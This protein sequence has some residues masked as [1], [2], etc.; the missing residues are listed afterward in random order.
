HGLTI[1]ATFSVKHAV[2]PSV[3][4]AKAAENSVQHKPF[5]SIIGLI[6][7]QICRTSFW[8]AFTLDNL[9]NIVIT[10]VILEVGE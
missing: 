2:K 6:L 3:F 10:P 5:L 7:R 4:A 8:G 1:M 9:S